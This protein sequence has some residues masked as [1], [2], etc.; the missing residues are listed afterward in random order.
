MIRSSSIGSERT[1]TSLDTTA[2][3]RPRSSDS[4]RE[5]V[6][7]PVEQWPDRHVDRL[8]G[9]HAGVEL[10]HVE[11]RREQRF[12]RRDRRGD[13][14]CERA[15]VGVLDVLR[16][17]VREHAERVQ[18]LAKVMARC[19]EEA[20]FRAACRF[21]VVPRRLRRLELRRQRRALFGDTPLEVDVQALA[22]VQRANETVDEDIPDERE[23]G[24]R[25]VRDEPY[26]PQRLRIVCGEPVV[27]GERRRNGTGGEQQRA[28]DVAVARGVAADC[29][30]RNEHDRD[31]AKS[32]ERLG[33]RSARRTRSPRTAPATLQRRTRRRTAGSR[34]MRTPA[35][36]TQNRHSSAT[37]AM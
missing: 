29:G 35:K 11:Q 14:L 17:C 34:T 26:R 16:H 18:R 2:S 33:D 3:F 23:E 19:G 9:D 7:Q 21:G 4:R 22:L 30:E 36:R 8:R 6:G 31:A 28:L 15:A 5:L 10:R 13:P 37:N 27:H 25:R 32:H 24:E 12:E 1:M 20:R